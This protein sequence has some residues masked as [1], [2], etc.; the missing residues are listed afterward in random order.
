MLCTPTRSLRTTTSLSRCSPFHLSCPPP[1]HPP[2]SS[3]L[4]VLSASFPASYFI[5]ALPFRLAARPQSLKRTALLCLSVCLC[6]SLSPLPSLKTQTRPPQRIRNKVA[7]YY[8]RMYK[9][10]GIA[11][12]YH[13]VE[14][15]RAAIDDLADSKQLIA[16][17]PSPTSHHKHIPPSLPA[18]PSDPERTHHRPT[19]TRREQSRRPR[20]HH[21]PSPAAPHPLPRPPGPVAGPPGA[22]RCTGRI[23]TPPSS[24]RCTSRT[25]A[26]ASAAAS[27]SKPPRSRTFWELGEWDAQEHI[28][29]CIGAA[30]LIFKSKFPRV[31]S[32]REWCAC[33]GTACAARRAGGRDRTAAMAGGRAGAEA[34]PPHANMAKQVRLRSNRQGRAVR[35]ARR[36]RPG[37]AGPCR[38]QDRSIARRGAVLCQAG[39][40]RGGGDSE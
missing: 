33:L 17:V 40:D 31:Y 7:E 35:R 14:A 10:H 39:A 6:L 22:W 19:H 1:T 9:R 26:A 20:A 11:S 18:S 21:R 13:S 24:A 23:T 32:S 30:P 15:F 2:F 5:F 3:L 37:T 16:S 38:T 27:A 29:G 28:L 34:S 4:P 8:T 12:P 25:T 36:A